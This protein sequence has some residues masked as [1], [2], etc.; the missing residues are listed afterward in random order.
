MVLGFWSVRVSEEE[1]GPP[2]DPPRRGTPDPLVRKLRA[3]NLKLLIVCCLRVLR[4]ETDPRLAAKW[5]QCV[6]AVD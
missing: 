5:Q 4:S 6:A 2:G 3:G 1:S